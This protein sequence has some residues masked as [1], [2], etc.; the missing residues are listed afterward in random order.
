MTGKNSVWNRNCT[1]NYQYCT[2]ILQKVVHGKKTFTL[3]AICKSLQYSQHGNDIWHRKKCHFPLNFSVAVEYILLI[4]GKLLQLSINQTIKHTVGCMVLEY[5]VKIKPFIPKMRKENKVGGIT[6]PDI[7]LCYKATVI[8]IV[9]YWHKNRH[10]DQWKR[11]E[12]PEI[13][14]CLYSQLIFDKEGRS[15]KWSKNSLFNKWC[16]EISI[17]TWK[18]MKLNH[19]PTLHTK[20]NSKCIKDLN[21]SHDTIKVLEENIDRKISDIP[22]SNIFTDMSPKQGT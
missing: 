12:S 11:I 15:I 10:I 5:C 7:K 20:I 18:K 17:S 13:N 4:I 22:C 19:Q 9:W 14:P 2:V 3:C 1:D 6:I 8:K 21:I 16:W